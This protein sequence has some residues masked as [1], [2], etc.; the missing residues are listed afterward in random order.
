MK[1]KKKKVASNLNIIS[2]ITP[3]LLIT[4]FFKK[5]YIFINF[6]EFWNYS[7]VAINLYVLLNSNMIIYINST[8]STLDHPHQ[9]IMIKKLKIKCTKF[10][11]YIYKI[12]P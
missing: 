11:T 8:L 10:K 4:F 2:K 1:K 3:Q 9:I 12:T 6:S 7:I 5:I